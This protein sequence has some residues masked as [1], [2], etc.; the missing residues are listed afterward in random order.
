MMNKGESVINK[1]ICKPKSKR[2]K[3]CAFYITLRKSSVTVTLRP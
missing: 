1:H 3:Q 2:I